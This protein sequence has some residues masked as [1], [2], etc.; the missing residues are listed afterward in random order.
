[1]TTAVTLLH[2]VMQHVRRHIMEVFPTQDGTSAHAERAS[3][4][5]SAKTRSPILFGASLLLLE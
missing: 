3:D 4:A 2:V 1:M 5:Y